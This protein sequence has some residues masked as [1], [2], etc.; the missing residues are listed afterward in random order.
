VTTTLSTE[1]RRAGGLVALQAVLRAHGK[2]E[3][4]NRDA[5]LV[6][7]WLQES[8]AAA[9]EAADAAM[10]A[11]LAE[12]E[13]ERGA[14]AAPAATVRKSK[15]KKKGR[16]GGASGAG[17]GGRTVADQ[18][19][20]EGLAGA[21][22]SAVPDAHTPPEQPLSGDAAS[23]GLPADEVPTDDTTTTSAAAAPQPDAPEAAPQA[24]MSAAAVD[25]AHGESGAS[26]MSAGGASSWEEP[27]SAE[28][29]AALLPPYLAHLSLHTPP[30]AQAVARVAVAGPPPPPPPPPP[31]MPPA[32]FLPQRPPS[33]PP[34]PPVM[35]ECCV[36]LL[37][38]PQDEL[39]LLMLCGH[40]CVCAECADTL[41]A[42]PPA[43]RLC[44]KCRKPVVH[45]SPVFDE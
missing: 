36:C 45:A 38:V 22:N 17:A 20:D 2:D 8:A 21:G 3:R 25:E 32:V 41:M 24:P 16:G 9:T 11:L 10:A 37:D 33:S 42:R 13:A 19:L 29:A 12:E 5:A 34:P 43:S 7:G 27:M 18:A 6:Y 1:A 28:D 14:K 35:K 39:H 44:P 26:P 4:V 15:G 40:R 30:R 31:P 23:V